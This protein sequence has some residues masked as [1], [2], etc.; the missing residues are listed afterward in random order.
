MD[1][2]FGGIDHSHIHEI[3]FPDHHGG[4]DEEPL[5]EV[6]SLAWKI[7]NV[8]LLTV[9]V[10]IGSSTS[11]LLFARLHLQRLAQTLSSRFAVVKREVLYRSPVLLTPYRKD[12]LIDV[13]ALET[14]IDHSY[15]QAG[16]EPGSVDTGA[17]ILTGAALERAN[18]RAVAD[19]FAREGGKFVCASAGHNLE[20]ILSSH[21][22][23]ATEL[24]HRRGDTLLHIDVGGG[25]CKFSLVHDG[26]VLQ[27]AAVNIGGRLVATDEDERIVRI[28][29]AALVI[30][31]E[32]G[33]QLGLGREL[34]A[35]E[36]RRFAE[37]E[38]GVLLEVASGQPLSPLAG[39]LM[40][41]PP[42]RFDGIE[43]PAAWSFSGGVAEYI[44]SRETARFGDLGA[45]LAAVLHERQ[46]QGAFHADVVFMGEGIRATVIGA[47]QFTL[48]LS[49]NTLHI[50]N[51]GVLP[52]R[53]I[54]VVHPRLPAELSIDAVRDAIRE[55]FR[56]LDLDEGEQPVALA[57]SWQ[58]EPRYASLRALAG[59]IVQ[60][61]P[62][63]LASG[64]PL[65]I[66]LRED[67]GRALGAILQED[68]EVKADLVS[69]DGLQLLELD[70][71]DIGELLQPANVVPVVVKSLAFPSRAGH[72]YHALHAELPS[73]S[74]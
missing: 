48:Q 37:V 29:P 9:G 30:A 73:L 22:S 2:D 59:G 13:E 14:F 43:P 71:I 52:I 61:M 40:L 4:E 28:E 16:L 7:D 1:H 35:A 33:L 15:Q 55:A 36:R 63:S 19:L 50:S 34:S 25:T 17:V 41:T 44:Y 5:E 57:V 70:Y 42:L 56:R 21:G 54:P 18:A 58:G 60:G 49:G 3:V 65:L 39:E 74:F 68:F 72:D 24:S 23:G 45:D 10:D 27:T 67:V 64:F 32:A 38:V 11:H 31:Q 46:Q 47:S 12:G 62:R 69:I 20:A 51:P 53:N 8:E 6:A 66:A 26:D